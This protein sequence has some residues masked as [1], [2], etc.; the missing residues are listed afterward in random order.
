MGSYVPA[1][2]AHIGVVDHLFTRIGASDRLAEGASTFM[3]E[4]VESA[5]ILNH[6]GTRSLVILDEV[7]RGTSTYDGL[8]IAW[9]MVERL[10]A[11]CAKTMFATH[12]HQMSALAEQYACVANFRVRVKVVG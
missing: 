6:A 7:G 2:Q 12:Y 5:H 9:A 4:M 10:A 8:A 11:I 3:V 1:D